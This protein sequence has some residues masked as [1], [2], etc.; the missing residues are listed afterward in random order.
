[1]TP[2]L[3]DTISVKFNLKKNFIPVFIGRL[4]PILIL[5]VISILYSRK[6]SYDDYGTFQ[7]FWIYSN[8][9]NII[10]AFA[11]PS[12]ILANR[13]VVFHFFTNAFQ[14]KIGL[15]YVGLYVAVAVV[16]YLSV[17]NL[18]PAIKC[19]ILVFIALQFASTLADTFL[20]K[21]NQL[22]LYFTA[23][24]IYSIL[25]LAIHLY[26]YFN[27]FDLQLLIYGLLGLVTAKTLLLFFVKKPAVDAYDS[28]AANIFFKNWL[29]LGTNE[30]VG[31]I[32]RWL[33][34]MYV[35][36]LLSAANFAIFVNG[37]IEIPLFAVLISAAETFMLTKISHNI[38]DKKRSALIF[39]ESFKLLSFI[40]FPVF[41][42]LLIAHEEAFAIVFNNRYNASVPIFLISIFIIPLR[43]NHYSVILQCYHASNKI[44]AGAVIDILLALVLMTFLYPAFG[45]AGVALAIVVST[46][47][48]VFYYL[49][50]SAKLIKV[51]MGNLVPFA[52]L[53]KLFF[54]LAL[55]YLCFFFLRYCFSPLAFVAIV[56]ALTTIVMAIALKYYLYY[57]KNKLAKQQKNGIE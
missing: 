5:V 55:L 37:T 31:V 4:L 52:F 27:A 15:F 44:L 26:F 12:I 2:G 24:F 36:F 51:G 3:Y 17:H 33:D 30:I 13:E 48:Q 47:V 10:V 6:L 8:I 34:K 1:M 18:S 53:A 45:V 42:M 43:I 54:G 19:C 22:N 25:F 9:L 56:F 28:T 35:V 20:I 49:W 38:A 50:Q 46:Y 39:K 23:N 40:S 11:M 57:N 14:K 7:T 16:F 41:F 21:R 29:Y 32:A